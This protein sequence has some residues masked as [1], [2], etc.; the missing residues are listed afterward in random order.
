MSSGIKETKEMLGFVLAI[1]EASISSMS[2]GRIGFSDL[3][4]FFK[5]FQKIGPAILGG[6]LILKEMVDLDTAEKKEL[7]DYAEKEFDLKNDVVELY[8]EK[9]IAVAIELVSLLSLFKKK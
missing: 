2:D 1:C 8:V 6:H 9:G 5:A 7:L 4:H 3:M